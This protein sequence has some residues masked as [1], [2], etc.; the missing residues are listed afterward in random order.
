VDAFRHAI[1]EDAFTSK[2]AN[3]KKRPG[4]KSRVDCRRLILV[5]E[6]SINFKP[7]KINAFLNL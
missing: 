7:A 3:K 6:R 4:N 1:V 2:S 5:A